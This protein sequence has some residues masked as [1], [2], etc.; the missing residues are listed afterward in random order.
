MYAEK[1]TAVALLR[2]RLQLQA[3]ALLNLEFSRVL[4]TRGVT[5]GDGYIH[6]N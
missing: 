3:T 1:A 2:C 4:S 5:M 6:G